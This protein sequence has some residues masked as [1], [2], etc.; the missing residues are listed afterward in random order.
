[1]CNTT[2]AHM[3]G[4]G[5]CTK[6]SKFSP[7]IQF[8]EIALFASKSVKT[9][10]FFKDLLTHLPLLAFCTIFLIFIFLHH[11]VPSSCKTMTPTKLW[12]RS[13]LLRTR[14]HRECTSN[15]TFENL[16]SLS[17]FKM[18]IKTLIFPK[19]DLYV[20]YFQ[21][22]K[23]EF[24]QILYHQATVHIECCWQSS[25]ITRRHG[26]SFP[27]TPKKWWRRPPPWEKNLS[28][29]YETETHFQRCCW[30]IDIDTTNYFKIK[31]A[32]NSDD[33]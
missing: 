28:N 11:C 33:F 23:I 16:K 7:K 26:I 25:S 1:M 13:A 22:S 21:K 20:G 17:W 29:A 14:S 19:I 6:C 31:F 12:R 9:T 10:Y 2:K 4:I 18:K 30:K 5:Y 24:R 8:L 3:C 15:F 32:K 27:S